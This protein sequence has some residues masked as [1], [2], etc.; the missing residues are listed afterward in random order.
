[1]LD[2]ESVNEIIET[3]PNANLK[4]NLMAMLNY[5]DFIKELIK[6]NYIDA[7]APYA[8]VCLFYFITKISNE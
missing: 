1:M 4:L 7:I 5:F 2:K 8:K 3:L 6:N